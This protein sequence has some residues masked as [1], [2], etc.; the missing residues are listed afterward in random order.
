MI[1]TDSN[2]YF[3]NLNDL[4]K[5]KRCE[6]LKKINF[7][8]LNKY[9]RNQEPPYI[10]DCQ[11]NINYDNNDF[12]SNLLIITFICFYKFMIRV[13]HIRCVYICVSYTRSDWDTG[14]NMHIM[15]RVSVWYAY[16]IWI[17]ISWSCT[18]TMLWNFFKK[19]CMPVLKPAFITSHYIT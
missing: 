4:R 3:I 17:W 8:L 7:F 9:F 11:S 19:D 5:K 14:K 10:N 18:R 2:E 12:E 6:N 16:M 15:S 1:Q 13:Y